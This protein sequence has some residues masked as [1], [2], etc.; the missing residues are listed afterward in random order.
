MSTSQKVIELVHH[1]NRCWLDQRPRDLE[2]VFHPDIVMVLPEFGG[3]CR[4][5]SE[6]IAS[7]EDFCANAKVHEYDESEL[8]VDVI[9]NTA[10]ASF[11]F[12][13]VYEREGCRYRSTGRD[14][15]MFEAID[16]E[17]RATWR[18]MLDVQEE[19]APNVS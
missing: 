16:G 13:M 5:A 18:T 11:R 3:R 7:F 15:W 1:I 14:L 4:G 19:D 10:T 9:G 8:S 17:W 6:L 2:A 12:A